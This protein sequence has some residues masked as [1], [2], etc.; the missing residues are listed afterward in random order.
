MT[1]ANMFTWSGVYLLLSFNAWNTNCPSQKSKQS[2][3]P[4]DTSYLLTEPLYIS[5]EIFIRWSKGMLLFYCP[6]E[7][8]YIFHLFHLLGICSF[9]PRGFPKQSFIFCCHFAFSLKKCK[10][11]S[12]FS[13]LAHSVFFRRNFG[14]RNH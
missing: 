11:P 5:F 12:S 7:A 13:Y 14:I 4:Y 8:V 3:I 9:I 1:S 2:F 6:I 10:R